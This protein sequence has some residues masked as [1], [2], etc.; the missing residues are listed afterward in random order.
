MDRILPVDFDRDT[1]PFFQAAKE[2]RLVYHACNACDRASHPPTR[3]CDACGG[4]DSAWREASGQGT[5]YSWTTVT[6]QVHPAY[7]APY[8]V[9]LVALNEA[10]NVR[11]VGT[12]PGAADLAAGQ[13]MSVWFDPVGEGIV[14]PQWA[15]AGTQ[16]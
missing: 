5:L 6:H 7:P 11:L 12:L 2:G 14:L 13:P 4:S 10:P 16:S 3:F 8:T 1:S 9:V 15:P